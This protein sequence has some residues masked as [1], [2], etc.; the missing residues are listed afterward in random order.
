MAP[1]RRAVDGGCRRAA[2]PGVARRARLGCA[3]AAAAGEHDAADRLPD[4]PSRRPLVRARVRRVPSGGERGELPG[5][6]EPAEQDDEQRQRR[7]AD[8]RRARR[9]TRGVVAEPVAVG[10]RP[11]QERRPGEAREQDE[12]ARPAGRARARAVARARCAVT[13]GGRGGRTGSVATTSSPTT[14][15]ASSAAV[16]PASSS[17][18]WT[19]RRGSSRSRATIQPI[20]A[21]TATCDERR[22]PA[23][24]RPRGPVA[25]RR[26]RPQTPSSPKNDEHRTHPQP[27]AEAAPVA[28]E[29][30]RD[31]DPSPPAAGEQV[32]CGGDEGQERGDQHD[33]DRPAADEALPEEDVARRPLR[34]ARR[35]APS[36]PTAFCAARPIWPSR[37]TSAARERA[38][39]SPAGGRP[40]S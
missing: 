7:V 33:L 6:G 35:P 19:G 34:R 3:P 29:R 18:G 16:W 17:S 10:E 25:A 24:G 5:R 8:A 11:E 28:A 13:A 30:G 40:R 38:P 39:A 31:R 15:R 2:S 14:A 12:R 21:R 9:R 26:R 32:D 23:S 37:A 27:E 22:R 20:P 4:R 1:A 36:R